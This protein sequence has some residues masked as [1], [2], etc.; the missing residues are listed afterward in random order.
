MKELSPGLDQLNNT[1]NQEINHIAVPL[2]EEGV[3]MAVKCALTT[4]LQW[5]KPVS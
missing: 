5:G 4:C 2:I 3:E 1:L